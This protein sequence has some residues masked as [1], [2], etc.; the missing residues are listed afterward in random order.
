MSGEAARSRRL[1]LRAGENGEDVLE[2][3]CTDLGWPRRSEHVEDRENWNPRQIV[4]GAGPG[5]LLHFQ[6]DLLSDVQYVFVQGQDPKAVEAVTALCEEKLPVWTPDSLLGAVDEARDADDR[7][8]ALHQLGVGAPREFDQSVFSRITEAMR[9]T[10]VDLQ[11][12]AI[13][14]VTFEPWPE[15]THPLRNV[16]DA[17][18][19]GPLS[20]TV[21]NLLAEMAKE[22]NA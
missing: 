20:A 15:Y 18:P 2:D 12:T 1:I 10:D 5:L 19:D 11:E 22:R 16:L 7:A 21:R 14:A 4:W 17:A 8:Y 6:Q 13:W 3:F 9:S